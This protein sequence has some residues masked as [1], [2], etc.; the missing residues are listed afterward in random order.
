MRNRDCMQTLSFDEVLERLLAANTRYHSDGY[1]FVREGLDYTQKRISKGSKTLGR[2]VT[3]T[4][5]LDGLRAHA[6]DQ[7]GPMTLTV[8]A[9]WGVTRC[10]DFGE[11]VFNLVEIGLLAKT[12]QDNRDHFKGG[13]DFHTAFCAPFL[14]PATRPATKRYRRV[15]EA[16]SAELGAGGS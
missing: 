5:L 16:E 13:Y 11:I 1:H 15:S 6:L 4:E 14:P 7:F 10:E 2:H 3:G 8:L 12:D 9:E